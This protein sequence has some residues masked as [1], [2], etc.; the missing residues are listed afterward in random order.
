VLRSRAPEEKAAL[1]QAFRKHVLGGFDTGV[2]RPVVDA[3]LAMDEIVEAHARMDRN[4]T[5]GKIVMRW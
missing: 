2:Y 5:F 1:A 4:E 3:T